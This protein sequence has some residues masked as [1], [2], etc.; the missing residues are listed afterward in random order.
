MKELQDENFRVFYFCMYSQSPC[1]L[2]ETG[3]C[4]E[5]E[6]EGYSEELY[7]GGAEE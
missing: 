7:E 5:C 4:G 2:E 1:F 3:L 6:L